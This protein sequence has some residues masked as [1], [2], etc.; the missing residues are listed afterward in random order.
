MESALC[1]SAN[2][3]VRVSMRHE[4][5]LC[6]K[7]AIRRHILQEFVKAGKK[8]VANSS[9]CW[10]RQGPHNSMV[11]WQPS[12]PVRPGL[13]LWPT[14]AQLELRNKGS[15]GRVWRAGPLC[16]V[17][18]YVEIG[19]WWYLDYKAFEP[20]RKRGWRLYGGKAKLIGVRIKSSLQ[21]KG[22]TL[23]S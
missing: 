21:C 14:K 7:E 17:R 12:K 3:N 22:A 13:Y 5:I 20:T 19:D 4:T 10:R 6:E 1:H 8:L 9:W 16:T 23:L 15:L 18:F 11:I 2:A